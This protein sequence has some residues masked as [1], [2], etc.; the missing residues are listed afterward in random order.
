M[1]L[2]GGAKGELLIFSPSV[3]GSRLT[4]PCH[5]VARWRAAV[6]DVMTMLEAPFAHAGFSS[7]KDEAACLQKTIEQLA[8]RTAYVLLTLRM[9]VSNPAR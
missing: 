2:I 8:P 5:V 7:G 6:E 9:V 1:G 4:Q 3:K